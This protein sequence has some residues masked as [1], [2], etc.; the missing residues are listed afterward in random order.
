MPA[1]RFTFRSAVHSALLVALAGTSSGCSTVKYLF[2]ATRGQL[3]LINHAKPIDEVVRDERTPPRIRKLLSEIGAIKAYGEAHGLKPTGNYT[4]Y[5]K[6]DR[7]APIW[8][9]SASE[10]LQF[11]SKV[12]HFFVVGDFPYLGWFD[13][14]QAK[15]FAQELKAEGLDVDVRGARAYSTLG[16]FRDAVLSSMLPE[17]DEALGDLINVI[18]HESVHATIYIKGQAYFNESIASFVAD[19][20]TETYLDQRPGSTAAPAAELVEAAP[21]LKASMEP[22][23]VSHASRERIAYLKAEQEGV[24]RQKRLHDA[25]EQLAKLYASSKSDAQKLEEKA[26]FLE[27]LKQDLGFH[28]EINNATL[29]QYKTYNTGTPEFEALWKSCGGD[30]HRFMLA[31][32]VLTSDSFKKPQQEDLSSVL[33]PLVA[34][35]CRDPKAH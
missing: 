26:K 27:K 34:A 12:W 35:N 5:V 11:K 8:V 3:S 32:Q 28:R 4:E 6:L 2:Q 22:Q 1:F 31:V 29:I 9:V 13:L 33:L 18:I 21:T 25:Y 20:L 24:E 15:D 30:G 7:P 23:S 14:A 17:G 16:Y 10:A 19:H